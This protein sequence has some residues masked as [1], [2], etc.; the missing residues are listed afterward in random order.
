[1]EATG[2]SAV[3][4]IGIFL[5]SVLIAMG[6]IAATIIA[7]ARGKRGPLR[8]K[9][10]EQTNETQLIQELH[11]GLLKMEKRIES[12]ETILLDRE[13]KEKINDTV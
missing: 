6:I 3:I 11:E 13:R 7:L 2:M 9:G 1:M 12:L 5:C 8:V 4:I 10:G